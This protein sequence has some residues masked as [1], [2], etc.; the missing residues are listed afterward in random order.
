MFAV[1]RVNSKYIYQISKFAYYLAVVLLIFTMF[2]GINVNGA[3]RWIRIPFIGLTFQSSDFAKLALLMYLSQLL[4]KKEKYFDDWKEGVLPVLAPIVVICLLILKDNLSTSVMLFML[5]FMLLFIGRF[6][7]KK[8]LLFC[9]GSRLGLLLVT[10]HKAFL[11]V[12]YFLVTIPG[13]PGSRKNIFILLKL[14]NLM[15]QMPKPTMQSLPFIMVQSR[16]RA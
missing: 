2:F 13:K 7:W 8:L 14:S 15:F 3:D 9:Y 11:K 10:V 16:G 4:V 6:P 12:G 5:S 1:H